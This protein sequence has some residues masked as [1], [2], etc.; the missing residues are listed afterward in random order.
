MH[1]LEKHL[2]KQLRKTRRKFLI[3]EIREVAE[4]VRQQ[5]HHAAASPVV[6]RWFKFKGF[7]VSSACDDNLWFR[8]EAA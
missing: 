6:A 7:K 8:V 2:R 3:K 4:A 1:P 5:G